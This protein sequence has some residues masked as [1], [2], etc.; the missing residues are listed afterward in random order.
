MEE[1]AKGS[2]SAINQL[3]N[4]RKVAQS[5]KRIKWVIGRRPLCRTNNKLHENNSFRLVGLPVLFELKKEI[6]RHQRTNFNLS[7]MEN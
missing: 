5:K 6:A 3:K 1:A 2:H 4:Q 7:L